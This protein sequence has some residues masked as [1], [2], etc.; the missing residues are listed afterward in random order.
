MIGCVGGFVWLRLIIN[1]DIGGEY[2]GFLTGCA[3]VKF[4]TGILLR[5]FKKFLNKRLV[6]NVKRLKSEDNAILINF[7]TSRES[8]RT[9]YAS[10][11]TFHNSANFNIFHQLHLPNE[12]ENFDIVSLTI[13]WMN[14]CCFRNQWQREI[15]SNNHASWRELSHFFRMYPE[16]TRVRGESKETLSMYPADCVLHFYSSWFISGFFSF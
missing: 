13:I 9:D 3:S 2:S 8:Y 11:V 7:I 10:I 5:R 12:R 6:I 4:S 14:R 1:C 16:C 15:V